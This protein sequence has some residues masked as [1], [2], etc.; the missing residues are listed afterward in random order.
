MGPLTIGKL[1]S[2]VGVGVETVRF[3]E[4]EGLLAEPP[5]GESGYR[6]Y[7]PEAAV[8]LGFIRHAKELGFSLPEIRELLSLRASPAASCDDVRRQIRAKI[9]DV[10]ERIRALARMKRALEELAETCVRAAPTSECPILEV[11][12]ATG[13]EPA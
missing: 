13:K 5:R 4:R 9:E 6:L 11:L 3:Y 1:A 7:P 12:E 2:Q 10:E 8:R